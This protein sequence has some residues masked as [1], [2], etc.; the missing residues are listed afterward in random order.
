M[1]SVD[2]NQPWHEL[3]SKF[4]PFTLEFFKEVG[5]SCKQPLSAIFDRKHGHSVDRGAWKCKHGPSVDTG[6]LKSRFRAG[7]CL[8]QGFLVHQFL[9]HQKTPA[10]NSKLFGT[11]KMV[12]YPVFW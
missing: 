8:Y 2:D 11:P 7:Y 5:F 9:V 4:Q 3:A 6:A 10:K 1:I 12:T